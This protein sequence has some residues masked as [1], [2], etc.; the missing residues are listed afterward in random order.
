MSKNVRFSIL[1][2]KAVIILSHSLNKALREIFRHDFCR[3]SDS[4]GNFKLRR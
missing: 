4:L 1:L 2:Q 3:S